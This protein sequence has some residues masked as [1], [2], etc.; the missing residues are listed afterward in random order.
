MTERIKEVAT[1]VAHEMLP[2]GSAF[3]PDFYAEFLTRCLAELA[4]DFEP[5]MYI[6]ESGLLTGTDKDYSAGARTPLYRHPPL[7]TIEAIE[8]A[9]LEKQR[10]ELLEALQALFADYKAL[11]DSGDAGFWSLE[12]TE[13]GK[14]TMQ[15]LEAMKGQ[16]EGGE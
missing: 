16:Q 1:K 15:I 5:V 11:A 13:V 4:K 9:E 3:A 14:R 6:H 12:K 2:R 7:Q 8:Y 10:D